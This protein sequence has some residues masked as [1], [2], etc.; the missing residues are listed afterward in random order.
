M[1]LPNLQLVIQCHLHIIQNGRIIW[2]GGQSISF[3]IW[4]GREGLGSYDSSHMNFKLSLH[5][6]ILALRYFHHRHKYTYDR[7]EPKPMHD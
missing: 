2:H 1:I 3:H 5:V 4:R 7:Q 6:P